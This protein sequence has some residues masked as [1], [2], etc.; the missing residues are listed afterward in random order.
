MGGS[1]NK[2]LAVMGPAARF[3]ELWKSGACDAAAHDKL[4]LILSECPL[5][6]RII[7]GLPGDECFSTHLS[8]DGW[9]RVSWVF[10]SDALSQFL[11][12]SARD[13]CLLLGFGAEWLDAKVKIGTVFTLA[14]FPSTS[15]DAVLADW[16]GVKHVLHTQYSSVSEKVE[17]HWSYIISTDIAVFEAEAGYSLLEVNLVGRDPQTGI[18]VDPR[19]MSLQCL[20]A[21]E[22]PSAVQVRQFL[23]DEIGIKGLFRGD[24]QTKDDHGTP[25]PL[26]Y[27]ARNCE[28]AK[29]EGAFV[30]SLELN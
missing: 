6:G 27:F 22:S 1:I 13:I 26:E 21:I 16:N 25:G 17:K 28:L 19:Y 3:V 23:W 18:S 10:G 14:I 7:H 29:I 15:V 9:K 5:S 30:S 20:E 8:S 24:G 12:R 4:K 2:E 11:G